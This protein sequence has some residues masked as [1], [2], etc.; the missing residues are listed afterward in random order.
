M[1][2]SS[3]NALFRRM[4]T[5][6]NRNHFLAFLTQHLQEVRRTVSEGVYDQD[7]VSSKLEQI[8]AFAI[9]GQT[10][11]YVDSELIDSLQNALRCIEKSISR[12]FI[13]RLSHLYNYSGDK[14]RPV[15]SIDKDFL[16]E[17]LE[18]DFTVSE[19]SNILHVS[20]RTIQRRI[21]EYQLRLIC[22]KHSDITE[23]ELDDEV[24]KI[25]QIFPNCG[26]RNMKGHLRSRNLRVKW[27]DVR[28]SLW[29]VDPEGILN[30]SISLTI[31]NRRTYSVP[32]PLALWHVDGNHKLVRWGLIVHGGV[33]G[34]TRKIMYLRCNDNN[35]SDT[36]LDLFNEAERSYGLPS[37]VRA[38]QGVENVGIARYMLNHPLRGPNRKSFIAGKSCHNQRIER[39]W[40]D[41]FS[42]VLY[43]YYCVFWH[44][45]NTNMIDI[46]NEIDLYVLKLVFIERINNDLD[47]FRL[48]WDNHSLRTEGNKTPNQLWTLGS[49][50]YQVL[51][52]EGT[53]VDDFFGVDCDGPVPATFED[54][55][56]IYPPENTLTASE[57]S[58][59]KNVINFTGVSQ[60]FGIDIYI[61]VLDIVRNMFQRRLTR[62]Q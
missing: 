56:E 3:I 21:E 30:R 9:H 58:N 11:G 32:G 50:S 51:Q 35:R 34:F 59:L 22:P 23:A 33:D 38:D 40:R 1:A 18:S 6:C 41:V 62:S 24:L 26:I 47:Q 37:R 19:I 36:V 42:D 8:I 46:S 60:S 54:N 13:S 7:H 12:E 27:E 25:L 14:G 31:I 4:V 44:L 16:L 43:K 48:G 55:I 2:Q 39:L 20:R 5:E 52:D 57:L 53:V 49:L 29:R 10:M 61:S 15:I 17:L 28:S 45:E